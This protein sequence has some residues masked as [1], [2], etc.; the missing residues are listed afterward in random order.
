MTG[1]IPSAEPFF[2]PGK[3]GKA[4]CLLIHGFTGTPKEM[5][6]LGVYLSERGYPSLGIRLSGHATE[7]AD[8]IRSR[9]PD[10][11][12]SV[13]DGYRLLRGVASRVYLIGLSMGAVLALLHS[14][15]HEVCGVVAMATPYAL[16]S[17]VPV[18]AISLLS[19]VVPYYPKSHLRGGSGWFD[20]DARADH[21]SYPMNPVRSAVELSRLLDA[22][23]VALPEVRVPVLLLHS[24]D[25]TYILPENTDRVYDGLVSSPFKE[26]RF[27]TGSGH[28]V[29]RDARREEVFEATGEFIRR[30]EGA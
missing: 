2:F 22:M 16:P 25:D 30:L 4:G 10:W 9:W 11:M 17:A 20:R 8:M 27:V 23:R 3:P 28:V 15:R 5:R 19:R 24:R 14:T 29:T 26:K 12:A 21:I 7:P 6:G 13:Q 18:W 1:I